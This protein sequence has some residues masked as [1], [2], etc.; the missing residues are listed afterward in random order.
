MHQQGAI[1][2]DTLGHPVGCCP[3]VLVSV[4]AFPGGLGLTL[5]RGPERGFRSGVQVIALGT[6]AI[7]LLISAVTGTFSPLAIIPS[8]VMLRIG[9]GAGVRGVAWLPAGS[10]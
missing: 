5:A 3:V 8:S 1:L 9:P 2:P 4:P 7:F 10:E 6:G